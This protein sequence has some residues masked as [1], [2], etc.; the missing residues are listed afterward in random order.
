MTR[1]GSSALLDKPALG[2]GDRSMLVPV[3]RA[4]R[5]NRQ[6][7][8]DLTVGAI[9]CRASGPEIQPWSAW[10]AAVVLFLSV[11]FFTAAQA[12]GQ[13][14]SGLPA[15]AAIEQ[16]MVEAIAKADKSVVAIAR[17]DPMEP[18]G[19]AE[20]L[21][22][23]RTP[24]DP[25]FV[26]D[27]FGTGVIIDRHGLIVTQAHVVGEKSEHYVTTVERKV[28]KATVKASD[29]RSD[30]AVLKINADDLTP[31]KFG[32]ASKLKKGQ[33]VVALG[34][35][36]AIARDGQASASWG[37]I[38][39][40]SRKAPPSPSDGTTTGK[41][42]LYHFGTL[43]QTDAKLN[44]GTSGGALVNLKGEMI[45]LTT[46]LAAT[47]GY[48]QAAG[49][50][51]PV[52][53][54]FLRAV[55]TLK[56][57]REME[58]G[59]LGVWPENLPEKDRASGRQGVRV[60][61]VVIGTPA[62]RFGVQVDDVVTHV[63]GEPVHDADRLMLEVGKQPVESKVRLTVLRRERQQRI[64]VELTKF[65]IRGQKIV[66]AP[67]PS[68]RGLHVDFSTASIEHLQRVRRTDLLRDGCVFVADVERDSPAWK[69]ELQPGMFVTHVGE[70]RV[71]TPK[72]FRTAILGKDGAVELR[73][74]SG[75]TTKGP[76]TRVVRAT[77]E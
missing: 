15:A 39:N 16:A 48:E 63:N 38:A 60:A 4:F 72:E 26:P 54:V 20:P 9:A 29:P 62:D 27:H 24:A 37:I 47:A 58:Y 42:K 12:F 52:D 64:E 8:P 66:T 53:D 45:G 68:W 49:Y 19:I 51:I 77:A 75:D 23:P 32:D 67:Q 74:F 28:Y 35:P 76:E 61:N 10:L 36:Y 21:A 44:L 69:A 56:Q 11:A 18:A 6:A 17:V 7:N 70:T 5:P 41:E 34:N 31:I 3:L 25:D 50:A 43:I 46:S 71:R 55:E 40:L 22:R 14:Q 57:G 13:Q 59:F 30:L 1:I 2:P 73:V 65:P 33:I